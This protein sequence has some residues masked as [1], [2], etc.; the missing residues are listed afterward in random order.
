MLTGTNKID[1]GFEKEDNIA[2]VLRKSNINL[3]PPLV[4]AQ[5]FD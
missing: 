5:D 2:L 1:N 4:T 3:C